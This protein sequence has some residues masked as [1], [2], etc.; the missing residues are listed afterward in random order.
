MNPNIIRCSVI[1]DKYG[2]LNML[3]TTELTNFHIFPFTEEMIMFKK[4]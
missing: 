4:M 2:K 1:K 3:T